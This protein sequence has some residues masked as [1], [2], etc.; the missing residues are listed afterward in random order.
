MNLC[1]PVTQDSQIDPR[2]G[3]ADRVAVASLI[4]GRI[5]DWQEF[6]V[7]WGALHDSGG[8]GEH[9]AR[10]A[11][12]LREHDVSVVIA[13]HMGPPMQHMLAKMGIAVHLGA[14]GAAQEATRRAVSQGRRSN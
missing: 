12:F 10:I 11:R 5:G 7:G 6:E 13:G 9:H 2:W 4:D 8:E 1:V 14:A 3:R